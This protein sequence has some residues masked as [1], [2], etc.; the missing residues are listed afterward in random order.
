MKTYNVFGC[1]NFSWNYN[2]DSGIANLSDAIETEETFEPSKGFMGEYVNETY[3]NEHGGSRE[4]NLLVR[5][6]D[7]DEAVAY[8]RIFCDKFYPEFDEDD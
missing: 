4:V 2:W 7:P 8:A 6:N 1:G 3:F 5:A